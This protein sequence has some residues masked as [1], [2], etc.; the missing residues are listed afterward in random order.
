MEKTQSA[1]LL[2]SLKE[3]GLRLCSEY[4]SEILHGLL[5]ELR[6][7]GK[8]NSEALRLCVISVGAGQTIL[9][10]SLAAVFEEG[11]NGKIHSRRVGRTFSVFLVSGNVLPVHALDHGNGVFQQRISPDRRGA[12]LCGGGVSAFVYSRHLGDRQKVRRSGDGAAEHD[13]QTLSDPRLRRHFCPRF[14]FFHL[15]VRDRFYHCFRRL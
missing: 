15:C 4:H 5:Q 11:R 6:L 3:D 1:T 12:A 13:H 10:R 2:H 7:Y 9:C 14:L 8:I